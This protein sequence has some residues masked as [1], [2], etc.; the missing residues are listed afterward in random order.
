MKYSKVI[1]LLIGSL[2]ILSLCV[3]ASLSLGARFISFNEVISTL[4]HSKKE[5]LN[6][7]VV[8]ER[9]PRTIFGIIAGAA[10]GVSGALMQAITRNPI[11]DPSVLGVNTG[12]SLFVVCGIAFFHI[13]S[14]DQYIWF[15][16]LGAAVTSIIV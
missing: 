10:L 7:M 3:L 8:H 1:T 11:A 2:F 12:A 9:I 5:T 16:L 14:A 13:G 6:E 15:A 4:I